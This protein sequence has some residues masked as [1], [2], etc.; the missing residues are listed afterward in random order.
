[1]GGSGNRNAV[2]DGEPKQ[3]RRISSALAIGDL[4]ITWLSV[5]GSTGEA[6]LNFPRRLDGFQRSG[7]CPFAV[8]AC[9]LQPSLQRIGFVK[10][11][12]LPTDS[13]VYPDNFV[14]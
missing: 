10:R 13:R 14:I 1:M 6:V 12:F 8:I 4:E 2:P 5:L 9:N 7:R 3:W 11:S